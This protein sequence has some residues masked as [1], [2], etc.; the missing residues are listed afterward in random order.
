MMK[1]LI[2]GGT[3]L[4]GSRLSHL[5][6]KGGYEVAHLSRKIGG[7]PQYPTY[8]WDPMKGVID[9]DIVSQVDFVIN[10]AGA[11][12]ADARWT[13]ARKQLIIDSRVK[14]NELL[15][16]AFEELA[17]P[18][19]AFISSAAIG[20]YGDRG[21]QEVME[22]DGPGIGFLPESC[23]AW[24]KSIELIRNKTS[25]RTVAIRI[26][27]VMST[28]GGALE[29]MLLP[30]HAL[31]STYFGNGQQWYS[32]IHLDDICRQFIFAMENEEM[33]GV[34]N[35]VA[36]NPARNKTIAKVLPKAKGVPAAVIPAPSL[37]LRL[38][39][40]EMAD[41]ILSG[42]KVSAAKILK[43]GFEFEHPELEAALKHLISNK[44]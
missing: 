39:M 24:E 10:L 6:T 41:A 18:P 16:H 35:G 23:V 34:Y 20:Y 3:G 31:T 5:L 37:A 36:P 15:L 2:A 14:G 44:L 1:V 12:V 42:T 22:D 8:H 26:G 17:K 38:A 33:E 11:G 13:A 30:L 27:L 43:A 25:I 9:Q 29:K 32:W 28:Q 21:E 7:N 19:K 4:I 40:G